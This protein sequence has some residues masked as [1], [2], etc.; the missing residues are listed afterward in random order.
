MYLCVNAC[1]NVCVCVHVGC[2]GIRP[3]RTLPSPP[4]AVPAGD[5]A[6]PP[7]GPASLLGPGSTGAPTAFPTAAVGGGGFAPSPLPS[8]SPLKHSRWMS[9][10][11]RTRN[12]GRSRGADA[13]GAGLRGGGDGDADA[14]GDGDGDLGTGGFGG[15][16]GAALPPLPLPLPRAASAG[17]LAPFGE[18]GGKEAAAWVSAAALPAP[19]AL[20]GTSR[21]ARVES[22]YSGQQ[23]QKQV[24]VCVC[25]CVRVYVCVY[26]CAPFHV[27]MCMSMCVRACTCALVCL[28]IAPRVPLMIPRNFPFKYAPDIP[29]LPVRARAPAARPVVSTRSVCVRPCVGLSKPCGCSTPR[30][31]VFSPLF[32]PSLQPPQ[33]SQFLFLNPLLKPSEPSGGP[34]PGTVPG[35]APGVTP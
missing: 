13:S 5:P 28:C 22:Q 10:R 11:S 27:H 17:F 20:P 33:A 2:A 3:A 12:A 8:V 29:P 19:P 34:V 23:V 30:H 15:A 25:A 14:D 6:L 31:D 21:R 16:A 24:R 4:P 35:P 1:V 32:T 7:H 9:G 18:A 26:E